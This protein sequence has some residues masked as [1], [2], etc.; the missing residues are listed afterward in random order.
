[1]VVDR[2][3]NGQGPHGTILSPYLGVD[4]IR[5]AIRRWKEDGE[6]AIKGKY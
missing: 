2:T 5:I 6:Q 1:M 4:S 3:G